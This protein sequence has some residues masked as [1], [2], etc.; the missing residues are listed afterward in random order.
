MKQPLFGFASQSKG[1]DEQQSAKNRSKAEV[2]KKKWADLF[3][4]ID[5][6]NQNPKNGK[7]GDC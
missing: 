6:F 5:V 7:K 1:A 4:D 2:E 3:A